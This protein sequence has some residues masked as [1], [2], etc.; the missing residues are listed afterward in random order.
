L[1][2]NDLNGISGGFNL[3][4]PWGMA[5]DQIRTLRYGAQADGS[6]AERELGIAYTPVRI[7]LEEAIASIQGQR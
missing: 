4:P 7:A 2:L 6:K 5:I 3:L 1:L